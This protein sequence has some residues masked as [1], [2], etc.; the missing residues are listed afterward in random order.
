MIFRCFSCLKQQVGFLWNATTDDPS[1]EMRNDKTREFKIMRCSLRFKTHANLAHIVPGGIHSELNKMN[2]VNTLSSKD[3][4]KAFGADMFSY[5]MTRPSR[6]GLRLT[7]TNYDYEVSW[8]TNK[9]ELFA[10]RMVTL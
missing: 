4:S 9:I 6:L 2:L 10:S 3:T 8:Q 7:S 1:E 5:N